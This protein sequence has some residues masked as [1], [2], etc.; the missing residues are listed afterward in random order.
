MSHSARGMKRISTMSKGRTV[1][2]DLLLR[3]WRHIGTAQPYFVGQNVAQILGSVPEY[4][5]WP[6]IPITPRGL[7]LFEQPVMS[8]G[9][10]MDA[11]SWSTEQSY[12]DVM[13]YGHLIPNARQRGVRWV[14]L[15]SVRWT[16]GDVMKADRKPDSLLYMTIAGFF[17]F[18]RQLLPT[19]TAPVSALFPHGV[20][21]P[22]QVAFVE[23]RRR[24]QA[25]PRDADQRIV[26]WSHRWVVRGFW[27][28]QWYPKLGRHIPR[29]IAPY[30]KGPAD[31]ELVVKERIFGV[32]R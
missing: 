9:F 11:F 25:G 32:V 4:E 16:Y 30:I 8:N 20:D 21:D 5:M 12:L 14:P 19:A 23:L 29:F 3:M 27:R 17:A 31:K 10:R 15:G 1:H 22:E 13:V 28:Q 18:A 26:E 2:S 7:V 6:D 24:A